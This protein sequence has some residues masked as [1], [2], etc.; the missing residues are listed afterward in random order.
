VGPRICI[1]SAFS[2]L[3]A[4]LVLAKIMSNFDLEVAP[5]HPV[6][7]LQRVTLRPG[8]GLP[9]VMRRRVT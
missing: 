3:E 1:G 7:P 6:W 4:T 2:L 5:D 9:M 8:G